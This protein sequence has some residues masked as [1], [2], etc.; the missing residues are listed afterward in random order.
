MPL[1]PR[2][3]HPGRYDFDALKALLPDLIPFVRKNPHGTDSIDFANP[4]AVRTLNRALLKSYYGIAY[5]SIPPQ[6][7]CPPIPGRGDAIHN[8]ADLLASSNQGTIPQGQGI[9]ILDVGVGASCIYPIIGHHEYKWSFVGSEIDLIALESAQE[10]VNRNNGLMDAVKLKHQK[11]PLKIFDELLESSD[12]FDAVICNP[13]FHASKM[14]AQS[15]TRRKWENLGKST[16]TPLNF[17]GQANELWCEGGELGFAQRMINESIRFGSQ[18]FWFTSLISQS[19]HLPRVDTLLQRAN[20]EEARILEMS[21]G[22]KKSRIVA[23]TFLT[24]PQQQEWQ[25]SRWKITGSL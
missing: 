4:E 16:Q 17:G 14:E 25:K 10:I 24:P 23:W 19:D 13:P 1:H 2:N 12:R 15:G 6:F 21:Q 3:R 18:C 9:R 20:V 11:S 8:L 7:L 22:Q 5:W